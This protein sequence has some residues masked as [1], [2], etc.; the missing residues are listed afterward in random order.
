LTAKIPTHDELLARA[1]ALLPLL[2]ANADRAE[3]DRRV[4]AENL[5]A[6]EGAGIFR[7]L[8]P[9]SCGGYG[10]SVRT[11]VDVTAELARGCGASAWL[12]FIDDATDWLVAQYSDEVQRE[13]YATG[14]DARIGGIFDAANA[15]S[16]AAEGGIVVSGQWGFGSGV[17]HATWAAL[18]VPLPGG[19]PG[20]TGEG[21][22][23][24]PIKELSIKDTWHVAG[25]RGTG[26]DTVIADKV[27]VPARRIMPWAPVFEGYYP[28]HVSNSVFRTPFIPSVIL[29][30][31]P[32]VLGLAQGALDVTLERLAKGKKL[33]Y[34]SY[35]DA[36]QA[37]STQMAVAEAAT[38]IN[39]AFLAVRTWADRLDEAGLHNRD[40][41]YLTRAQVRMDVGYAVT[42]CRKAVDILLNVQGA[43]SFAQ[44]NPLQ[45]IWRDLSTASRHA[46]LS[47]EIAQE[48]YGRALLGIENTI[49]PL[50]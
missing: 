43:S 45:R 24:I 12:V 15:R 20:P 44:S 49:T 8:V 30:A 14:P 32:P 23:L 31:V 18:A 36:R 4:P 26:S 37:P 29:M 9:P 10:S 7:M 6:M 25:M 41:D 48:I 22:V 27:F 2:K 16:Q 35:M 42:C 40:F 47:P 5:K 21:L 50:V 46:I 13:V 33:S 3:A 34:T 11:Y 39:A 19:P 28:P 38:L 17:H 1:H